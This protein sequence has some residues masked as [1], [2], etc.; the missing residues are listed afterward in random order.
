MIEF[1]ALGPARLVGP[2]GTDTQAVL[3]RPKLLG[4][5][6]FLSAGASR[7]FHRRDSLIGCFWPELSQ[8]RARSAVR[9][10]LYRLRLFLGETVV[11]TRGDDE[12]AVSE[13]QF[14]SDVAGFEDA[15][16]GGDRAGALEL[17]RGDLLEGLYV[18]DAPE[19]ERWL[20][21]RRKHLRQRASTAAWELA[22]QEAGLRHTVEAGR[23]SRHARNLAPLDERLL[24][25]VIKLLDRLGDRAGAVREYETFARRVA[26]EL[27]L[28]PSPETKALIENVRERSEPVASNMPQPTREPFVAPSAVSATSSAQPQLTGALADRYRLG[29]EIG[30]GGMA[31]VYRARD[32]RHERNVAVKV[33]HAGLSAHPGAE[34]FL[35]EIKIAANL[36]HPHIVPVY[37]SGSA[38]GQLYFVMP[39]IQGES[40]RGRLDREGQLP[41]DDA[42][43]YAR[44][45]AQALHYAHGQGVV[46]RDV[47]PEN[48]LLSGDH[49]LV[50]DFGIARA[51]SA[52]GAARLTR[53]GMVMGTP[54]YMSPEQVSGSSEVDHRHD[55]YSFGCVLYEMLAGQ[56]PF[57]GDD[58][59]AMLASHV[60]E[61]PRPLSELR[62]D[63]PVRLSQAI[64]RCLE[65]KPAD[66]WD[67]AGELLA[68]LEAVA[69]PSGGVAPSEPRQATGAV[70]P[71]SRRAIAVATASVII[72]A[73]ASA[74]IM[75]R[76]GAGRGGAPAAR[77]TQLTF[78]GNVIQTEIS[79]D[80]DLLA[81]V[82]QDDPSRL[83]V[84]DLTGGTV[85][86]IAA[87]GVVGSLRWSPDGAALLFAGFDSTGRNVTVTYPRLGGPPRPLSG[88][89][90]YVAWASDGSQVAHW[91]EGSADGVNPIRFTK[92]AMDDT[93]SV[94]TPDSVGAFLYSG[95]WSPNGRFIAL[96]SSVQSSYHLWTVAVDG[97]GWQRLVRDTVMLAGPR[98]APSGGAV[99]YLRGDEL[100][101]VRVAPDGRARGT[102]VV[103]QAGLDAGRGRPYKPGVSL[104]GDGRTLALTKVQSHSN[105][106]LATA[107]ERGDGTQFTTVQLTQGTAS[108]SPP[109]LSPDGKWV[110]YIQFERTEGDVYVVST[111]G[112]TP[113]RVTSRGEA[114]V[115]PVWSP[116]G[117]ALAFGARRG[118]KVEVQ[119]ILL[120]RGQV[121]A[122]QRTE[123]GENGLAWA[124]GRHI[125]YSWA[126]DRDLHLLDPETEAEELLVIEDSVG[127]VAF[128]HSSPNGARVAVFWN[129]VDRVE[130]RGTWVISLEYAGRA[131][132]LG[133]AANGQSIYV[134]ERG[135]NDI[136][137]V[138]VLGGDGRVVARVPFDGAAD[139]IPVERPA[140]LALL[141]NVVESVSDA[142][143]IENFDPEVR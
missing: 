108:K 81:Y 36:T 50:A 136:L 115:G 19:F 76:G 6:A 41:L 73:A 78:S 39:L 140:S 85:I 84:K 37:D 51:V 105:V 79:P 48:I 68:E 111:A 102:P 42:L 90:A 58:S 96:V 98:W 30:S 74:V 32:L 16:A 18:P 9:Q 125:V 137:L 87:I 35:R 31:T 61:R 120:D 119:T 139:C 65:K 34:R 44:D 109:R 101:K 133:W 28:D 126:D 89:V 12:V 63:A 131:D 121:R 138:P 49:A 122:Y 143:M 66:R 116:D 134:R 117:T 14:W 33:M 55:L 86:E 127:W 128:P 132:P 75:V 27:E 20:D 56:P 57:T 13:E 10:S 60:L 141:C 67:T 22:D 26:L 21:E 114:V 43:T 80:G 135:S 5:L 110:A 17:Y 7:G 11:V 64:M 71:A 95:D 107:S 25:R 1:R 4:L 8:E 2:E 112:G 129:R 70:A 100:R 99:Y 23:W 77:H 118:G 46:H 88:V 94:E 54:G 91:R 83:F 123:M 142:W 45:V 124:P 38:A 15:L 3:A 82:E 92:L 62:P 130:V 93:F 113:R 40:L 24:R 72:I 104:T 103:L 106:W 69:T 53:S 97:S 29:L 59:Q 52:A 47:K